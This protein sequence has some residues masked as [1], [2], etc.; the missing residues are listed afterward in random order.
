[1][2]IQEYLIP[3]NNRQSKHTVLH[4]YT[5][6]SRLPFHQGAKHLVRHLPGVVDHETQ[7]LMHLGAILEF[8]TNAAGEMAGNVL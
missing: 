1:M 8:S 7:L 2:H 3:A 5:T 4:I 6:A